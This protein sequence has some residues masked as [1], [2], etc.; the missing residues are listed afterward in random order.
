MEPPV[1]SLD[2]GFLRPAVSHS[3]AVRLPQIYLPPCER[4]SDRRYA[5][6]GLRSAD[7]TMQMSAS[8]VRRPRCEVVMASRI[9]RPDAGHSN[10]VLTECCAE[11]CTTWTGSTYII[12]LA[13]WPYFARPAHRCTRASLDRQYS[14]ELRCPPAS[15]PLASSF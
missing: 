8:Y 3:C 7:T 13:Q 5:A 12:Y 4:S 1:D 6:R 2:S 10:D 11:I 9:A 15:P 14:S